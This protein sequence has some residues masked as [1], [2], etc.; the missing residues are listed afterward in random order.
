MLP[1]NR[2]VSAGLL[3]LSSLVASAGCAASSDE[4]TRGDD[5]NVTSAGPAAS[6]PTT[7][8]ERREAIDLVDGGF[9]RTSL[10]PQTGIVNVAHPEKFIVKGNDVF[11]ADFTTGEKEERCGAITLTPD[12]ARFSGCGLGSFYERDTKG[13]AAHFERRERIDFVEGGVSFMRTA[14]DPQT[15]IINVAHPEKF[16]VEGNDVFFVQFATG[17]KEEKC[18]T[19]EVHADF[20]MFTGCDLL[21]SYDKAL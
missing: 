12:S 10:D 16:I 18:G 9:L 20:V 3:I 7:T 5:Q 2:F 15:G 14:L 4:G 19:I 13:T 11:A 17:E 1:T 8:Y 6:T 21:S